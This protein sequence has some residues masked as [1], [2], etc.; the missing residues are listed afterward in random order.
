[1]AYDDGRVACTDQD[2]VIRRYYF[3]KGDKRIPY[4]KIRGVQSVNL[5]SMG[6]W[7]IKSFG[8]ADLTHWFNFDPDRFSKPTAFIIQLASRI[9]PVVTP[10]DPDRLA[11]ELSAH[12]VNVS[13]G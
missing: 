3:P 11:A 2:L 6:V 10:A 13:P 8:S 9:K 1:M 12:G 4:R 7:R 5:A